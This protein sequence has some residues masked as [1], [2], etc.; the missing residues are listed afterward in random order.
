MIFSN[1]N[2]RVK[3]IFTLCQFVLRYLGWS[4]L[5]AFSLPPGAP[6]RLPSFRCTSAR[7]LSA[8]CN[9]LKSQ[10]SIFSFTF[11]SSALMHSVPRKHTNQISFFFLIFTYYLLHRP[12]NKWDNVFLMI[13]LFSGKLSSCPGC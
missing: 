3:V 4:T 10:L 12:L 11:F 1:L 8:V 5:P 9:H 6:P 7:L 13:L 2:T